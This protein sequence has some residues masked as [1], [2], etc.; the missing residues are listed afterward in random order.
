MVSWTLFLSLSSLPVFLAQ[1]LGYR[2]VLVQVLLDYT[3]LFPDTCEL[4]QNSSFGNTC[5]A[6][7]YTFSGSAEEDETK[8]KNCQVL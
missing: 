7:L 4:V 3:L 6:T 1:S 2:P 5:A 8:H